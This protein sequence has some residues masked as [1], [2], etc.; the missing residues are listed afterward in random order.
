MQK[1][2][3]RYLVL[4][5]GIGISCQILGIDLSDVQAQSDN[6]LAVV[7]TATGGSIK[8]KGYY[9]YVKD[10]Q[11]IKRDIEKDNAWGWNFRGEYIK[12]V[13]VQKIAGDASYRLF[14]I[15]NK[16]T[17]FESDS[18]TSSEPIVY[19]KE[20]SHEALIIDHT[21]TDVSKIPV[22]WTNKAKKQFRVW[23]G[24]T[25][26]GSQITSGMRAMMINPLFNFNSTGENGALSY[27]E[28]GGDLG[29]CGD[30]KWMR[31][32]RAQLE[33]PDNNR[34]VIMWSWCGGCSDNT[35]EGINA[36]LEAMNQLEKDYP[37]VIF[38]YMTGHLDG[39]GVNGNLNKRNNQIRKYC[40]ANDKVLFDFADIESFDPA[41]K[42]FLELNANDGCIYKAKNAGKRN[43][44]E[45]WIARHPNHKIALPDRAAH[46]HPLNGA[47]KGRAFWWMMSKLAERDGY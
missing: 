25:S 26:H 29:H 38:I 19:K 18:V 28:T 6:K 14:V 44:A 12:E 41:G 30:M 46:T 31:K 11:D 32:T 15:E 7:I 4:V 33:R 23:Y 36:Y 27:H 34:N 5:I 37:D 17:V 45:E 1:Q 39:T 35:E 43:W 47:L 20:Q 24:H 21:C 22:H 40:K 8:I 9:V 3:F 10:G 42:S 16:E 13:K 2:I